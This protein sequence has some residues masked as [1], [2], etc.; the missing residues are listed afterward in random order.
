VCCASACL[1]QTV[2][3]VCRCV[4]QFCVARGAP[5]AAV[6]WRSSRRRTSTRCSSALVSW[7]AS[8]CCCV[9]GSPG[10]AP[11]CLAAQRRLCRSTAAGVIRF[12]A[13][14]FGGLCHACAQWAADK[15]LLREGSRLSAR[16]ISRDRDETRRAKRCWFWCPC[17]PALLTLTWH[18]RASPFETVNHARAASAV[19]ARSAHQ[20]SLAPG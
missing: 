4:S 1:C 3:S 13:Q 2:F 9:W 10:A 19:D 20:H 17:G 11:S 12:A 7:R 18:W 16:P 14:Q 8:P 15:G 6:K 5:A